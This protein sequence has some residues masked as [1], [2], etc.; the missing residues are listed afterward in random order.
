MVKT[1]PLT[2]AYTHIKQVCLLF[3]QRMSDFHE[4]MNKATGN[5]TDIITSEMIGLSQR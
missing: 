1:F 2:C 4:L 3:S 5:F